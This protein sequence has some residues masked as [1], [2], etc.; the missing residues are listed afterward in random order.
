MLRALLSQ[1][2]MAAEEPVWEIKDVVNAR[3]EPG[4]QLVLKVSWVNFDHASDSWITI[5]CI[6]KAN[7]GMLCEHRQVFNALHM[8]IKK[9]KQPHNHQKKA[10]PYVGQSVQVSCFIFAWLHQQL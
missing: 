7:L 8:A 10:K 5:D 1:Q 2:E 6:P 4:G 3:H 9:K